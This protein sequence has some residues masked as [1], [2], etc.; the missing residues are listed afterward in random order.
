MWNGLF[1]IEMLFRDVAQG[2]ATI[3]MV[4]LIALKLIFFRMIKQ[5]SM[6]P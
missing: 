6:L 2:K 3:D 1:N 4:A 5:G